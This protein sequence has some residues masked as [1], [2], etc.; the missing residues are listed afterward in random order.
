MYLTEA[1][2]PAVNAVLDGFY[3]AAQT[4]ETDQGTA[5]YSRPKASGRLVLHDNPLT[6]PTCEQTKALQTRRCLGRQR[7]ISSRYSST[8]GSYYAPGGA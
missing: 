7:R 4:K 5:L 3:K 2:Q 1:E 6:N 8:N